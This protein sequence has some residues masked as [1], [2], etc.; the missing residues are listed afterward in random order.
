MTESI[1]KVANCRGKK[2]IIRDLTKIVKKLAELQIELNNCKGKF[3]LAQAIKT[4][5]TVLIADDPEIRIYK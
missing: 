4:L 5:E 1:F 2:P 3:A